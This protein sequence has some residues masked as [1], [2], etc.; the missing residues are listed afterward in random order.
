[1]RRP[2]PV[3]P[4]RVI[5]IGV[6]GPSD[7]AFVRFLGRCG[8]R[9]RLRLHLDVKPANGGDTVAV[10]QAAVR[11]AS[12]HPSSVP[13]LVL[14][15]EDRI[16]QDMQA[17]RDARAEASRNGLD[18][19]LQSPN[20]EG[21]LLRLHSGYERRR[22]RARDTMQELRKV[23]PSYSKS[24]T[25]AE[26]DRR[27]DLTHVLRAAEHDEHLRSPSRSRGTVGGVTCP[28]A[29]APDSR[30]NVAP[31]KYPENSVP[32]TEFLRVRAGP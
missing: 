23:W 20:L 19:I 31:A 30:P 13:R 26:W 11:H 24:L 32:A 29:L 9:Q 8:D 18:L 22:I 16:Q 12:R 28:S 3:E 7:R 10:V 4:R 17:G 1:M 21:V 14:L 5:C 6:E 2:R 15:D 27:F 25:A